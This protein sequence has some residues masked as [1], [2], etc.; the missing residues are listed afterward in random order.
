M[1]VGWTKR[2]SSQLAFV[3]NKYQQVEYSEPELS[4]NT[5]PRSKEINFYDTLYSL[6]GEIYGIRSK[7]SIKCTPTTT[8]HLSAQCFDQL[9]VQ[10]VELS[11][12]V[13]NNGSESGRSRF[14][15]S[16]TCSQTPQDL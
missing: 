16:L 13:L 15:L 4:H 3:L 11:F 5:I 12:V 2:D 1:V 14:V 8:L 9:S 6:V 7:K 10:C